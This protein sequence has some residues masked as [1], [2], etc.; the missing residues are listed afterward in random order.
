MNEKESRFL[1]LKRYSE[2]DIENLHNRER[3]AEAR[4]AEFRE[5]RQKRGDGWFCE[6][7]RFMTL[8]DIRLGSYWDQGKMDEEKAREIATFQACPV[9]RREFAK[10]DATDLDEL[11]A[12]H[13]ADWAIFK[14]GYTPNFGKGS[15]ENQKK[16]KVLYERAEPQRTPYQD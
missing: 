2:D 7:I 1:R 5:D 6:G 10:L 9:V 13:L 3:N 16:L 8:L 11:P 14:G 12:L 4:W 15:G